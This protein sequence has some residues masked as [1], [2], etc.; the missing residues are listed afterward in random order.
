MLGKRMLAGACLTLT[1][2]GC[3]AG[4]GVAGVIW[5]LGRWRRA[6]G[7]PAGSIDIFSLPRRRAKV[8][9]GNRGI[10]CQVS[11]VREDPRRPDT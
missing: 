10:R 6:A 4:A 11:G 7:D 9:S 5:R 2:A 3:S 8:G 1:A